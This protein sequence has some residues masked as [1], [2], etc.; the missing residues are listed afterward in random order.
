VTVTLRG[1]AVGVWRTLRMVCIAAVAVATPAVAAG[2]ALVL[3]VFVLLPGT[4]PEARPLPEAAPALILDADGNIIAALR[5]FDLAL[6]FEFGDVPEVVVDAVVS[7]EDRRFFE[8]GGIDPVG[9]VRAARSNVEGVRQGGSTITQQLVKLR[10]FDDAP[11]FDRKL[12]EAIAAQQLERQ[13]PKDEILHQYLSSAYFGSGATGLAAA[14]DRYFRSPVGELDVSEAAML[15]GMLPAPG[16]LSPHRDLVAAEAARLRVLNSMVDAGALTAAEA[17]AA[18]GRPIALVDETGR[19]PDGWAGEFTA[20]WPLPVSDLGPYPDFTSEVQRY[21]TGRFGDDAYRRGLV[22]TTTLQPKVQ[23]A[24]QRAADD[25]VANTADPT[26]AAAVAVVEPRTGFVR[27]LAD[28]VPFDVSQVSFATGG[29]AGFQVGSAA[30]PFV[31]AAA[32]EAGRP[33]TST[34]NAPAVWVAPTGETVRNFGGGAGGSMSLRTAV[35]QSWNTPFTALAADVGPDRV[36]EVARRAGVTSWAADRS[37]GPSVALGA[38]ETSPLEMAAAFGTFAN[39]GVRHDPTTILRIVDVDGNVLEDNTRRPGVPA[40]DPVVAANVTDVL[41]GVVSRG[42]GTAARLESRPAAGK[43]GT[44][45]NFSSA[46]FVGF[47]PQLS[48]SVWLGHVDGLRPLGV[49]NGVANPTGGSVPASAWRQFMGDVLDGVPA[50]PFPP[51]P[52]LRLAGPPPGQDS[53]SPPPPAPPPVP[54]V[55]GA[56]PRRSLNPTPP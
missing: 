41:T 2:V 36:A 16:V 20:V 52:P 27:A 43:T 28:S 38:Y 22:V 40:F 10:Y 5:G 11:T 35:E 19:P 17:E 13:L 49:V 15:A 44:A 3:L 21:L 23:D 33:P 14:A 9:I 54:V 46:W 7:A 30:K 55:D 6:P 18:A 39:G 31:L 53:N 29:D 8:H 1:L 34:V 4:V 26:V 45:E 56:P 32:L 25:A 51:A 42:T 47:T 12:R 50:M 48:A 24:A 37:Y